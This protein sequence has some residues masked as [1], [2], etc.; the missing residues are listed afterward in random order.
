M[1]FMVI[2]SPTTCNCF[3]HVVQI[4][5]TKLLALL[6]IALPNLQ[7]KTYKTHYIGL[8]CA[9]DIHGTPLVNKDP[10]DNEKHNGG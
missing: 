3:T 7:Y 2:L 10:T 4:F 5:A 9:R 1:V 6:D 8:L